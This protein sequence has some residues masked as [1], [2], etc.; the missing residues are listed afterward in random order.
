MSFT[1]A[2][3][4]EAAARAADY[5]AML[6]ARKCV[7]LKPSFALASESEKSTMLEE[8]MR[9]TMEKRY[10]SHLPPSGTCIPTSL[11]PSSPSHW[12]LPFQLT[13]TFL[14]EL[15][16]DLEQARP[17]PGYHVQAGGV[18]GRYVPRP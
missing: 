5:K 18:R 16:V 3:K 15:L 12:H 6:N 13:G 10:G 17:R 9:D 2:K 4:V 1:G 11:T 8:A 7:H 14:P